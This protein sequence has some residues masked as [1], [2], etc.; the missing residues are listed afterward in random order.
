[1]PAPS[2]PT[3]PAAPVLPR[4]GAE[5]VLQL[6][7]SQKNAQETFQA[8]LAGPEDAM[9]LTGAAGTGKSTL[10]AALVQEAI[11][12]EWRVVITAPTGRA[13]W[14]LRQRLGKLPVSVSE[15]KRW[16]IPNT[17]I[18]RSSASR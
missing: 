14:L 11:R 17:E 16:K 13:A 2:S 4:V 8:F 15:W 3:T 5:A 6:T 7:P 1:M 9:V 10:V 18:C 12:L